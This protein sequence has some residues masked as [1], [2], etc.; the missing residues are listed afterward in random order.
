[1][2]AGVALLLNTG[3]SL[4]GPVVGDSTGS[5][6]HSVDPSVPFV[7]VTVGGLP[8][9]TPTLAVAETIPDSTPLPRLDLPT[10]DPA[11]TPRPAASPSLSRSAPAAQAGRPPDSPGAASSPVPAARVP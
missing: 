9:A 4:L 2:L 10:R 1:V 3:C 5:S 8:A 11:A 7:V 6:V